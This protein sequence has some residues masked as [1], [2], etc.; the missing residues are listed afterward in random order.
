MSEYGPV[1]PHGTAWPH[2]AV[3][4]CPECGICHGHFISCAEALAFVRRSEEK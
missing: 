1:I 4:R 3:H 2:Q